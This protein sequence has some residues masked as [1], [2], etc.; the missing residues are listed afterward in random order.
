ML[1]PCRS[2][3]RWFKNTID[4][5]EDYRQIKGIILAGGFKIELSHTLGTSK[6]LLPISNC[7]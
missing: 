4:Y 2:I 7:L 6:Q 5:F 1:K 3:G